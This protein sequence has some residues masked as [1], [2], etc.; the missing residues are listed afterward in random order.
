M[1]KIISLLITLSIFFISVFPS[2]TAIEMKSN[3][4]IA[5]DMQTD[6]ILYQ[7]N[8]DKKVYPAGLTKILTALLVIE[9]C[10][11]N[12]IVT[13]SKN[14]ASSE[15][16][17]QLKF[18]EGEKVTVKDLLYSMIML[19]S[20]T[21]AVALAEHCSG[22]IDTF[23]AKINERLE[24]LKCS[25]TKFINPTGLHDRE[26]YT[27]VSDLVKLTRA[28]LENETFT[29]LCDTS[30]YEIPPTNLTENSRKFYTDNHLISRYKISSY[31]TK[32]AAGVMYGYTSEAGNC[33]IS[34]AK[35]NKNSIHILTVVMGAPKGERAAVVPSFNDTIEL[36]NASLNNFKLYTA[37]SKN[38]LLTE[39][40]VLLGKTKDF[41]TVG[42]LADMKVVLPV[43]YDLEKLEKKVTLK[44][45]IKAPV[46]I[47]DILGT[48]DVLYDGKLL[49]TENVIALQDV[50]QNNFLVFM[51]FMLMFTSNIFVKLVVIGLIIAAIIYIYVTISRYKRRKRLIERS[52][53]RRMR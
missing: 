3:N 53:I 46:K 31:Q 10:N 51:D 34:T 7:K 47:G 33:L 48:V 18:K 22:D 15:Y 36:F 23:T 2:V 30:Y 52:R 8:I 49:G 21:A 40:H 43:D 39:A 26:H 11:L 20:N 41:T 27:T 45:N 5:I 4:Y 44:E 14:A 1:K 17:D 42:G 19:S 37:L 24:A 16:S 28:A 38:E 12:D 25:N 32:M 9:D 29:K 6:T 35:K 50:V 13:I